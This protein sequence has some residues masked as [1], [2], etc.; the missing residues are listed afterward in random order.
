[1]L[2]TGAGP[3]PTLRTKLNFAPADM[4]SI[5]EHLAQ[6]ATEADLAAAGVD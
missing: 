1:M 3:G 4:T 6:T 5:T 2:I